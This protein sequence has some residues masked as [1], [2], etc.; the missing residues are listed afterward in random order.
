MLKHKKEEVEEFIEL[1]V[2]QLLKQIVDGIQ[3]G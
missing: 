3:F 1:R 2:S